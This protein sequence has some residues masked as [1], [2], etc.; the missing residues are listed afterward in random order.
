MYRHK[1]PYGFSNYKEIRTGNYIYV[2]KTNYIQELESLNSKYLVFLRPRR[3]GKSLFL[4]MLHYYYDRNSAAD[5]QE[6]FG[7]TYIG[8]H[9]TEL[10][11][12]ISVSWKIIRQIPPCC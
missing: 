7:D 11:R 5:F 10:A 6:L 1:I 4:S 9:K 8:A 2:D 3:F 12:K